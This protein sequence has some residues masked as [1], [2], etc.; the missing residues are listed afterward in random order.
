[1]VN[2][3]KILFFLFQRLCLCFVF[4]PIVIYI[5]KTWPQL[6]IFCVR[7]TNFIIRFYNRCINAHYFS[8]KIKITSCNY[9]QCYASMLLS[10][11]SM[12]IGLWGSTYLRL[13]VHILYIFSSSLRSIVLECMFTCR[14]TPR[15]CSLTSIIF[16]LCKWCC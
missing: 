8:N 15:L 5:W 13:K 2:R 14:G 12:L 4:F 6:F 10:N 16:N 7:F 11:V 1:M 3:T 9:R